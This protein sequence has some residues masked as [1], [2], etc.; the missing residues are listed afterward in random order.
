MSQITTLQ[1]HI[2]ELETIIFACEAT[3]AAKRIAFQ[4]RLRAT[5]HGLQIK[6]SWLADPE[7]PEKSTYIDAARLV[8]WLQVATAIANP[9]L[10][11]FEDILSGAKLK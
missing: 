1:K 9:L 2:A 4:A 11:Q 10:L 3:E 7:N 8:D 5:G 6:A